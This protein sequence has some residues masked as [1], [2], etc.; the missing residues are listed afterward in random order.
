M[1]EAELLLRTT[2]LE[3]KYI[4]PELGFANHEHL[5]YH[6]KEYKGITPAKFR[7]RLSKTDDES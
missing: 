6:F 1:I 4:V 7:E 5:N 2:N 3:I